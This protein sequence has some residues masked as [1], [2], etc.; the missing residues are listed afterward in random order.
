MYDKSHEL[1]ES[2]PNKSE[3]LKEWLGWDTIEALYRVEVVLHNTNVRE[4]IDRYGERLYP[5]CGE[6]SNIPERGLNPLK[7]ADEK[8]KL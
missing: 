2:S 5:E 4:F 6:H 8:E 3:R 1:N 7:S